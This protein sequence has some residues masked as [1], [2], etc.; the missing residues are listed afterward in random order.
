MARLKELS[1]HNDSDALEETYN[2]LLAAHKE[3]AELV[4]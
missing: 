2:E 3:L 4:P 1:G